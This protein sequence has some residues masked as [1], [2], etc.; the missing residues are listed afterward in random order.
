MPIRDDDTR[1]DL[2]CG[3]DPDGRPR[4]WYRISVRADALRPLGLHPDQPLSRRIGSFPRRYPW[5]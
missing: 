4:G 1:V 3:R 5:W 2:I